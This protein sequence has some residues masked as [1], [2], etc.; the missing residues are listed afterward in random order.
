MNQSKRMLELAVGAFL[1]LAAAG[2]AV[3]V[4]Q[5]SGLTSMQKAER[6][7][8]EAYFNNASGLTKRAKV[9]SAGVV[10]GQVLDIELD[11]R[12]LKARVTLAI[13]KHVDYLPIDSIASIQTAGV[14]GEKY[15]GISVGAEDEYLVEG[16]EIEDTTSSLVLEE[17]IGKFVSMM[18]K[19]S[20]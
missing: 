6:Y 10:I 15:I 4:F 17:L 19:R 1:V 11:E 3:L 13:D 8:V 5:V 18:G 9:S 14:L 16:S 12:T 7:H 2:M 20:G